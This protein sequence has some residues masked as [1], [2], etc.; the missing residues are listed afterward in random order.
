LFK[1]FL[2]Y[3]DR[4]LWSKVITVETYAA[5]IKSL[6][7]LRIKVYVHVSSIRKGLFVRVVKMSEKFPQ[8]RRLQKRGSANICE[9]SFCLFVWH[10]RR[11]GEEEVGTRHGTH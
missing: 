9:A 7:R 8:N 4:P 1:S 11:E 5:I 3:S 6:R 10:P 2:I